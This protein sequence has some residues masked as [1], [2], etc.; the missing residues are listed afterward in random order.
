MLLVDGRPVM[1]RLVNQMQAA[2]CRAIRIVTRPEKTDVIA[3]AGGMGVSVVM[4]EPDT[5]GESI[6]LGMSG[7][8]DDASVLL[9]FPDTLWEPA[10]GFTILLDA[11]TDDAE[12]VLGLFTTDEPERSD[13]VLLGSDGRVDR[14]LVKPREPPSRLIWG[15]AVARAAALNDIGSV[16]QPGEL[17]DRLARRGA[18]RGIYLS[19]SWLDIGTKEALARARSRR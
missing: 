16:E 4:G 13:V 12:G 3:H 5:V 17:F 8:P 1:D 11:L 9:G 19:D 14:I 15:C 18:I 10:N 7:V 2:G 6:A